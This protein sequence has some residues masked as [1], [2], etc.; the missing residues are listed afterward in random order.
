MNDTLLTDSQLAQYLED[1][2]I[3]LDPVELGQGFHDRM[4]HAA[5]VTYGMARGASQE[6]TPVHVEVIGDNL[7]PRIAGSDELLGCATVKSAIDAVLGEDWQVYPHD[8]IH[9]SSPMDQ[10]FHQDG[11]LPWND[12][13]HYRSHRLDWAMLFYYP[14][15]TDLETGPTEV[16]PGTQYWTSDYELD[17]GK[18]HKGDP[19]GRGYPS[20]DL[21]EVTVEERDSH[22]Q[23][24]AD[25]WGIPSLEKCKVI[26]PRGGVVLADYDLT[27]R[28]TR[29]LPGFEGRR[30][31][32]KYYLYRGTSPVKPLWNRTS[33]RAPI[34]RDARIQN[35]VAKNW[36]WLAGE[37]MP[38][39]HDVESA[40]IEEL[41]AAGCDADL[42]QVAYALG[43]AA[44]R[45]PSLVGQLVELI[46]HERESIRRAAGYAF[47]VIEDADGS[48][49]EPL[50]VDERA[51]VRRAAVL[52]LRESGCCNQTTIGHLQNRLATDDD[53]LVRSNAAYALGIFARD[54]PQAFNGFEP[55]IAR[56]DHEVEPDNTDNGGMSRSTVRESVAFALTL[57]QLSSEEIAKVL[58]YAIQEHDRYAKSLLFIA[59]Q[60]STRAISEPWVSKLVD[61]LTPKRFVQ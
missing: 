19:I 57:V 6:N 56:L 8:F 9:E 34:T 37:P 59:V 41:L 3:V 40:T 36:H 13:G 27:H 38:A 18:W 48:S 54:N 47:G 14:Q 1:G 52:A 61:Y 11:N 10:G 58:D 51:E 50:L 45:D 46:M 55:W 35:I 2:Y 60:R 23:A 17:N 42:I 30:F 20:K 15:E 26:V 44:N 4:Y 31:M 49:F 53:D 32:Y 7:R 33:Q 22:I 12:R 39:D 24:V 43:I 21:R 28:G 5:C 25:S 16:I 29:T